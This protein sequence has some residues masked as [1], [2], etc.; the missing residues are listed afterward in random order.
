MLPT[1]FE[2]RGAVLLVIEKVRPVVFAVVLNSCLF[3]PGVDPGFHFKKE[4][5]NT[6]SRLADAVTAAAPAQR[7]QTWSAH[8]AP[9][10]PASP[11]ARGLG[12]C[13]KTTPATLQ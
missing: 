11:E 4:Q 12:K 13:Q 6:P 8:A 10:S 7:G 2:I 1:K 9:P 5:V 3:I